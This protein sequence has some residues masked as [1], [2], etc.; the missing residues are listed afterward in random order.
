MV[1]N[2]YYKEYAELSIKNYQN[3]AELCKNLF[4]DAVS[5]KQIE[6]ALDLGCGAGLEL[7]PFANEFSSA[8]YGVDIGEELGTIGR[9]VFEENGIAGEL[10][11]VR[12]SGDEIP[13]ADESFDVVLCRVSLPYMNNETAISEI[14]RVLNKDGIL[15]LKIHSPYF[16]AG[17]ILDAIQEMQPKKVVY[18]GICMAASVSYHAFGKRLEG[19]I[20]DGKE[21]YQTENLLKKVLK[22]N[23]LEI[24]GELP[25]SNLRTPSYRIR[26]I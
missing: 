4:K 12:G 3:R 2:N 22:R 10:N 18:V 26:K 20:W 16:Y 6:R 24:E 23:S 5:N 14:S 25:D 7:I 9:K 11:F 21:V 8:C 15:L 17:M 13:F 19:G 1:Q